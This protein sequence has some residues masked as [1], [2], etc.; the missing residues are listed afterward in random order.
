M[1][2]PQSPLPEPAVHGEDA[3]QGAAP[4]G[5]GS[6]PQGGAVA[7]SLRAGR[8][9]PRLVRE[10]GG[11]AEGGVRDAARLRGRG[12]SLLRRR[13]RH[14]PGGGRQEPAQGTAAPPMASRAGPT[15][16]RPRGVRSE[17]GRA[18]CR[19]RV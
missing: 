3:P 15:L 12:A 9:P 18:S 19:E 7:R 2:G 11:S 8:E 10:N 14:R 17:I 5:G 1:D 13:V 4:A 6:A 16:S